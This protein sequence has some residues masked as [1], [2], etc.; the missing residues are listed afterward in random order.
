MSYPRLGTGTGFLYATVG[1]T[2]HL[3]LPNTA[4]GVRRLREFG[5][6]ARSIGLGQRGL[7]VI[8]ISDITDD[9]EISQ[10]VIDGVNQIGTVVAYDTGTEEQT[11]ANLAAA[12]TA[13]TP[14]S[15]LNWFAQNVGSVVYV[16]PPQGATTAI[17]GLTIGVADDGDITITT[18]P[19]FGASGQATVYNE[20]NGYRF[21]I[22][23][24]SGAPVGDISGADEIT[25]WIVPRSLDMSLPSYS[26]NIANGILTIERMASIS[27]AVAGTEGSASTDDCIAITPVGFADNDLLLVRAVSENRVVNFIQDP[28]G[29]LVLKQG[30]AYTSEGF[31]TF[32]AFQHIAGTFYEVFRSGGASAGAYIV[33]TYGLA[34]LEVMGES[35]I[36]GANYLISDRGDRGILLKA[37][38]NNRFSLH[39]TYFA[40]V[41]DYQNTTGVFLGRWRSSLTPSV[42]SLVAWNWLMYVNTTGSNGV[43][44]PATDTT[45][46]TALPLTDSRYVLETH[47]CEFDFD[48]DWVVA[49]TDKRNNR[50]RVSTFMAFEWIAANFSFYPPEQ[51]ENIRWFVWGSDKVAGNMF[52]QAYWRSG[53]GF[54]IDSTVKNNIVECESRFSLQGGGVGEISNNRIKTAWL[55][56]TMEN[57][58]SIVTQN[59]LYNCRVTPEEATGSPMVV[60]GNFFKRGCSKIEI[61]SSGVIYP[62]IKSGLIGCRIESGSIA[63]PYNIFEDYVGQVFEAGRSTF[64]NNSLTITGVSTPSISTSSIDGVF[65]LASANSS[66][67][68][69]GLLSGSNGNPQITEYKFIVGT[70]LTLTV[71]GAGT[72]SANGQFLIPP[73][74]WDDASPSGSN[75]GGE[76]TLNAGD[77]FIITRKTVGAFACWVVESVVQL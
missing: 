66:E 3:T 50:V 8:E 41:P 18:T 27:F 58:N 30:A 71:Q 39:G 40:A 36:P 6:R 44:N 26:Q 22:N 59:E 17:N 54:Y 9:G 69:T 16:Y 25:K 68:I 28:N 62:Y 34:Q 46:W 1:S 75:P 77:Y 12:I 67:T 56:I 14:S 23:A 38:S 31:G 57:N 42:N 2:I 60:R 20:S 65:V 37:V 32:I 64:A 74:H 51:M 49:R 4:D 63:P 5:V 43:S 61:S 73:K 72:P 35:L 24:S 70:G 19:V 33:T 53:D 52:D 45:N 76:V 11:A 7:G 55:Q 10:V 21:Y 29:N 48:L 13:H 47:Y 15:G